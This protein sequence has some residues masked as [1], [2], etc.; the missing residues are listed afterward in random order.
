MSSRATPSPR[1]RR[2][3]SW[4]ASRA[5]NC[6]T[7]R[8]SRGSGPHTGRQPGVQHLA[9]AVGREF[10]LDRFADAN[11]HLCVPA[12][13]GRLVCQSAVPENRLLR[14]GRPVPGGLVRVEPV[15]QG[16]QLVELLLPP[17]DRGTGRRAGWSPAPS[18][19]TL[20][21]PWCHCRRIVGMEALLAW[22]RET[23]AGGETVAFAQRL[24][25]HPARWPRPLSAR[26]GGGSGSA[27][28]LAQ[29]RRVGR[30]VEGRGP[31]D[32]SGDR[33]C[34]TRRRARVRRSRHRFF[35]DDGRGPVAGDRAPDVHCKGTDY[36]V[37]SVPERQVVLEYG[38]RT[39]IVGDPKNHSTRDFP[40]QIAATSP[41]RV[42]A[43]PDDAR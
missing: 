35:G 37:D 19:A 26:V 42:N 11:G 25:R 29:R 27:D 32:S 33:A 1:I 36:T 41:S 14:L 7:P 30:A 31:P 16:D 28:C 2:Y 39:A 21:V 3:H 38:G 20:A 13:Y 10:G 18:A 9:D 15:E 34:G 4:S 8:Q 24:L 5:D 17:F 22:V 23:R 43:H 40:N 6:T 12:V